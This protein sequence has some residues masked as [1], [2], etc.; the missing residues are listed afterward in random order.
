MINPRTVNRT[1]F[2]SPLALVLGIPVIL[3]K[4]PFYSMDFVVCPMVLAP[5]GDGAL[6]SSGKHGDTYLFNLLLKCFAH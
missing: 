3:R 2:L 6:C 4:V 1:L 5:D